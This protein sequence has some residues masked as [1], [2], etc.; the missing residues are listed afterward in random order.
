MKYP[1]LE[2]KL[3]TVIFKNTFYF[4]DEEF[5]EVYEGHIFSLAQNIFHLKNIIDQKG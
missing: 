2:E 4:Y 1:S 5:E 3:D